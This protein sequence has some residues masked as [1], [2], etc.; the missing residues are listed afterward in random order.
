MA[1][2]KELSLKKLIVENP[3]LVFTAK[4]E[5]KELIEI[6]KICLCYSELL[7]NLYLSDFKSIGVFEKMIKNPDVLRKIQKTSENLKIHKFHIKEIEE[8]QHEIVLENKKILIDE[9]SIIFIDSIKGNILVR[10]FND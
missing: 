9:K 6:F 1:E 3:E 5:K 2:L 7:D 8:L 4:T 10:F